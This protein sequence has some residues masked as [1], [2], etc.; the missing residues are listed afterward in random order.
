MQSLGIGSKALEQ[1]IK[2]DK[3]LFNT[4]EIYVSIERANKLAKQFYLKNGFIESKF[5]DEVLFKII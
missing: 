3:K 4:K 1:F 5:T 2:I